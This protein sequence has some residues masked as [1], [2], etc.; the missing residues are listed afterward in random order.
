[1]ET[2]AQFYMYRNWTTVSGDVTMTVLQRAYLNLDWP[3]ATSRHYLLV[4]PNDTA[5]MAA[6]L[7]AVF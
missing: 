2:Q 3:G 1:M 6:I 4:A 7:L 5:N